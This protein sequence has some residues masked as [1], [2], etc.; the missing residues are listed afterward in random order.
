MGPAHLTNALHRRRGQR[1][2]GTSRRTKLL[3]SSSS[4]WSSRSSTVSASSSPWRANMNLAMRYTAVSTSAVPPAAALSHTRRSRSTSPLVR[5]GPNLGQP[6]TS[7]CR[8]HQLKGG[9]L[10]AVSSYQR[11]SGTAAQL[12]DG[13]APRPSD[14]VHVAG[15]TVPQALAQHYL[16]FIFFFPSSC[17]QIR[18][19]R[20]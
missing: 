17:C 2:A 15:A 13:A 16:F 7:W 8:G 9:H 1:H 4:S 10:P 11:L 19:R 18:R 6:A 12:D 3:K 14:G 5:M 20:P